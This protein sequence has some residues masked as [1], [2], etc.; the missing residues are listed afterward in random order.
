MLGPVG[1]GNATRN[2]R[3]ASRGYIAGLLPFLKCPIS[4]KPSTRAGI[5][6]KPPAKPFLSCVV[7]CRAKVAEETAEWWVCTTPGHTNPAPPWPARTKRGRQ[8]NPS[9]ELAD[10]AVVGEMKTPFTSK[11][12]K[13]R[14]G[15]A[16][17]RRETRPS[18][19]GQGL[20]KCVVDSRTCPQP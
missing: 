7:V 19:S 4:S 1:K 11:L 13:P 18:V 3:T 14:D 9:E 17:L 12:L 10:H 2:Q 20:L 6:P 16:M 5:H 8:G 15:E